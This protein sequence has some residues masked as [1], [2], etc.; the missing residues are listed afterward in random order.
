MSDTAITVAKTLKDTNLP[1]KKTQNDNKLK[2]EIKENL[3]TRFQKSL[4][5]IL[6]NP[7]KQSPPSSFWRDSLLSTAVQCFN[8]LPKSEIQ[9]DI[10]DLMARLENKEN[11]QDNRIAVTNILANLNSQFITAELQQP[12]FQVL[13]DIMREE[14]DWKVKIAAASAVNVM[15]DKFP[16]YIETSFKN[17]LTALPTL[18]ELEGDQKSFCIEPYSDTEKILCSMVNKLSPKEIKSVF[19]ELFETLGHKNARMRVAGIKAFYILILENK[20]I[21]EVSLVS[22]FNNWLAA[23]FKDSEPCVK[24]IAI[25]ALGGLINQCPLKGVDPDLLLK[26]LLN[27]LKDR[28]EEPRFAMSRSE[29]LNILSKKLPLDGITPISF[30]EGLLN[31]VDVLEQMQQ[32]NYFNGKTATF[33]ASTLDNLIIKLSDKDVEPL[34]LNRLLVLLKNDNVHKTLKFSIAKALESLITKMPR[35]LLKD[36]DY[37]AF[38]TLRNTQ[39]KDNYRDETGKVIARTFNTLASKLPK[40]EIVLV[41][42]NLLK[43][44]DYGA[45]IEHL[46]DD[47][48]DL[49]SKLPIEMAKPALEILLPELKHKSWDIRYAVARA[50]NI[51]V[52]SK[53]PLKEKKPILENLLQALFNQ[54]TNTRYHDEL[55]TTIIDS[56]GALANELRDSSAAEAEP[57]FNALI[58]ILLDDKQYCVRETAEETFIT[59]LA[60]LPEKEMAFICD[61]FL[62]VLEDK[63]NESTDSMKEVAIKYLT[64]SPL[65]NLLRQSNNVKSSQNDAPSTD[66][67]LH[68][69]RNSHKDN[70]PLLDATNKIPSVDDSPN[71]PTSEGWVVVASSKI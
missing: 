40:K 41:I 51:L 2:L 60:R 68:Q 19:Q 23:A 7:K 10:K 34:H 69:Y 11:N 22:L 9:P 64:K 20:E 37:E 38:L 16:K 71:S 17:L 24:F 63:D 21:S 52:K 36:Y 32:D 54:K 25:E 56:L 47:L 67:M 14:K 26:A 49:T 8:T 18:L 46:R 6:N 33:L 27:G 15:I 3:S 5:A 57:I 12:V 65:Q 58:D 61:R 1:D 28:D 70:T 39:S 4:V 44:V 62:A 43:D 48:S 42:K 55:I 50:L 45:L 31:V 29:A 13:F 30:F 66:D 53:L 35:E 59:L